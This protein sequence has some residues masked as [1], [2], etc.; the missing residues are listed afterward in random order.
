MP[1]A[2][3]RSLGRAYAVGRS[4]GPYSGGKGRLRI[5]YHDPPVYAI[6]RGVGLPESEMS[7]GKRRH[8]RRLGIHA[9]FYHM[10]NLVFKR[11]V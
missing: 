10:V 8:L 6:H 1:G 7:T 3:G 5:I 11:R 9:H 2:G 4:G